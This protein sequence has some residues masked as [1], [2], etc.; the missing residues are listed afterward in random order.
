MPRKPSAKAK[1]RRPEREPQF[2]EDTRAR[3]SGFNKRKMAIEKKLLHLSVNTGTEIV[4]LARR[5]TDADKPPLIFSSHGNLSGMLRWLADM[6]GETRASLLQT[7]RTVYTK[8]WNGVPPAVDNDFTS[9]SLDLTLPESNASDSLDFMLPESTTIDEPAVV[10][11][12]IDLPLPETT[13]QM[14]FEPI[15]LAEVPQQLYTTPDVND[16]RE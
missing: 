4:L 5:I 3:N 12:T 14:E 10:V 7:N 2:V 9:D 11:P 15:T 1:G 16:V 13:N 8:Y 6:D